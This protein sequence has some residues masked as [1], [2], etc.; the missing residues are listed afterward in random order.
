MRA[1]FVAF[2]SKVGL[3]IFLLF[4][5]CALIPLLVLGLV[6]YQRVS[7][8]LHQT[9]NDQLLSSSRSYT[10]EI[11]SRLESMESEL[12]LLDPDANPEAKLAAQRLG[13]HWQ[14]IAAVRDGTWQLLMG[15]P[16]D[17]ITPA[18]D[19]IKFM[20]SGGTLLVTQAGH[21]TLMRFRDP[22]RPQLGLL[23]GMA[24]PGYVFGE[25]TLS[26]ARVVTITDAA[27]EVLYCTRGR[28]CLPAP[29]PG[30]SGIFQGKVEGTDYAAGFH[31]LF[32]K[33][34]LHS[35]PWT[36]VVAERSSDVL[37]PIANFRMTFPLVVLLTLW[38]V[39]LLCSVQIRHILVPLEHLRQAAENVQEQKFDTKVA[40]ES[41]DEFGDVAQAFNTMASHL[42][43]QFRALENLSWGTLKAQA[44]AIDAKSQWTSGH[45]ERVTQV[46]MEIA[47]QMR[48]PDEKLIVLERGGLL[49]D[50]GK[51][52]TPP[53]VLDKAGRLDAAELEIMRRH[54]T[55]G[56]RILEPITDF[57]LSL[58]IVEQHHEAYDGSG[59]PHGLKGEKIDL[60]ARILAVA[61]VYDALASD[62][63]YRKGVP[64]PDV[65]QYIRDGAGRQFDPNV[66]EAFL[67]VVARGVP[68][69]E[70]SPEPASRRLQGAAL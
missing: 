4:V 52:G 48:L 25:E 19:Q 46:A 41:S 50:I 68:A 53:S 32:L 60:L 56:V 13:S 64:I 22:N 43:R 24:V 69:A 33:A 27:G 49:H 67:H 6:A 5:A 9:A 55:D 14:G 61:D 1:D 57:H 35:D 23:A 10:M 62:R 44:R 17:P 8:Q 7:D 51:I 45:S 38:A 11:M 28:L 12:T 42:G 31:K 39:I 21:I 34:E 65:I 66:V 29:V 47:R 54:V 18:A 36:A 3:R 30:T 15:A 16:V 37:A 20:Q 2:R 59:Y 63:P 26:S 40:V 70:Y 58:P